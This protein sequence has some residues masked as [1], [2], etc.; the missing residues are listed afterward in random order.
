MND[1]YTFP[2]GFGVLTPFPEIP[3][4]QKRI[5]QTHWDLLESREQTIVEANL[6]AWQKKG[7]PGDYEGK[8]TLQ[9]R[10]PK[11]Q[12]APATPEGIPE[13]IDTAPTQPTPASG[14]G[15]AI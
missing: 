5:L 13:V 3:D 1:D 6:A 11:P 2:P 12:D 4:Y 9:L 8:S 10:H 15:E 14:P 7:S